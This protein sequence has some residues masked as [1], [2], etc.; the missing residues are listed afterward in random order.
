MSLNNIGKISNEVNSVTNALRGVSRLADL[1]D[2]YESF[3]GKVAGLNNETLKALFS[4]D[5]LS[6]SLKTEIKQMLK[7]DGATQQ[8]TKSTSKLEG[9]FGGLKALIASHPIIAGAAAAAAAGYIIYRIVDSYKQKIKELVAAAK[10]SGSAYKEQTEK[11]DNYADRITELRK[12]IDSG[13]LSEEESYKAKTELLQIQRDLNDINDGYADKL[14]LVNGKLEDQL[15]LLNS[16][17]IAEA[18]KWITENQGGIDEAIKQMEAVNKYGDKT[19]DRVL[20]ASQNCT[21]EH[22]STRMSKTKKQY[23]Q[24]DGVQCYHIIQSFQPGEVTPELAL[25]IA[26]EFAKEYLSEYEVVIGTHVDRH[27]VHNHIVFNSVS[28]ETWKKYHSSP[29]S[30]YQQIRAVSD[31]L[32]REHGLSVIMEGGEKSSKS[33]IEWPRESKGQPTFRSMLEADLKESIVDAND[34]GHF[35]MIMEH[36]GYEIYHGNRL[37]F[38]LR[39]QERFTYPGRQNPLFTE[40]GIK[41]AIEGN[42]AEIDA[43]RKPAQ[44]YRPRHRPPRQKIK[45]KGFVALYYHYVYLLGLVQKRQY[46]PRM[47]AHMHKEVMKF[48]RYKE[49]FAFLREHHITTPKEMERFVEQTKAEIARQEQQRMLMNVEKKQRMPLYN[50]LADAEA[51]AP[52]KKLYEDGVTGLEAEYRQY[53]RAVELLAHCGASR[54]EIGALKEEDY[55]RLA[56]V[57]LEIKAKRKMLAI[58]KNHSDFDRKAKRLY[59]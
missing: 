38:R 19:D 17:S 26:Q 50:A 36:K 24:E 3:R 27:H 43:G 49:Q 11:I 58:C 25:E 53:L 55:R 18:N 41:A 44:V 1:G 34:L 2:R 30:Y 20:T 54:G 13:T 32:C 56:E 21:T 22:A 15:E 14:D 35:F 47:T 51:L 10:E 57:N 28:T 37:G 16:I 33:Y 6:D 48:K 9:A 59:S 7:L 39:G 45:Y 23:H 40:A 5:K 52:A 4:S 42:M 8:V 29:Q 46:P 31:R 12:Q